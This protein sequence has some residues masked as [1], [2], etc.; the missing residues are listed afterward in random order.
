MMLEI[1]GTEN[2]LG[3]LLLMV[4]VLFLNL[5]IL[6]IDIKEL[7]DKYTCSHYNTIFFEILE[8]DSE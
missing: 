7:T 2:C 6:K 3:I 5:C 4:G 1:I 8:N